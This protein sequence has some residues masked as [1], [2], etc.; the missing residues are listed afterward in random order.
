MIFPQQQQKKTKTIVIVLGIVWGMYC[1]NIG[2]LAPKHGGLIAQRWTSVLHST[3]TYR[4]EN[5]CFRK[6]LSAN[7]Q[8]FVCVK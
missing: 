7:V 2:E 8:I 3:L 1:N 6:K 5:W 4:S